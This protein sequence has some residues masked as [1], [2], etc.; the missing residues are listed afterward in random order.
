MY[1]TDSG[2]AS[3]ERLNTNDIIKKEKDLTLKFKST[4][5]NAAV[6]T[7]TKVQLRVKSDIKLAQFFFI[8]ES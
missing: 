3:Q 5:K 2:S 8:Q 7:P 6:N 1:H 4:R